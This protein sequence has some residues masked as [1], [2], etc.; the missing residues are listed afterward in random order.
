MALGWDTTTT[1]I[2]TLM[3]KLKGGSCPQLRGLE[4]GSKARAIDTEAASQSVASA[5][6]SSHLHSLQSLA[7][8]LLVGDIG[9]EV[10]LLPLRDECCPDLSCLNL[11]GE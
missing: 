10:I 7:L 6:S 9:C 3:D 8:D 2:I 1:E 11:S 4:F 5:L